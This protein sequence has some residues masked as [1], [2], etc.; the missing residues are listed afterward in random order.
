MWPPGHGCP[1]GAATV[2]TSMAAVVPRSAPSVSRAAAAVACR[3]SP[4]TM[5]PA[6]RQGKSRPTC[7]FA[8]P[9]WRAGAH[10]QVPDR[11]RPPPARP[12]ARPVRSAPRA[13]CRVLRLRCWAPQP[14]AT[15]WSGSPAGVGRHRLLPTA[16]PA[17]PRPPVALVWARPLVAPARCCPAVGPIRSPPQPSREAPG[18]TPPVRA[19]ASHAEN[20]RACPYRPPP[21]AAPCSVA[22]R[23]PA[24]GSPAT[25]YDR[26]MGFNRAASG[27]PPAVVSRS[28]FGMRER[29]QT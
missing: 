16:G 26:G 4:P 7:P 3:V 27:E 5:V 1:W 28:R 6:A 8:T 9:G 23:V 21:L 10:R 29:R 24:G 19:T 20:C 14:A 18:A 11:G 15:H 25:T 12:A 13:A 17:D 2:V 22:G